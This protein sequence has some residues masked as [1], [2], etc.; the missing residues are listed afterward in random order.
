MV[1][2]LCFFIRDLR[3]MYIGRQFFHNYSVGIQNL[4]LEMFLWWLESSIFFLLERVE[5]FEMI[6]YF[7]S[8][9][10]FFHNYS[11]YNS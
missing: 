9:E 4:T 8:R 6:E 7:F 2:S 5:G 11:L 3:R 10:P 1:K